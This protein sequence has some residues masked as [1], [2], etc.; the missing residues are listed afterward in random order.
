MATAFIS[1]SPAGRAP[2]V[3]GVPFHVFGPDLVKAWNERIPDEEEMV[4]RQSALLAKAAAGELTTEELNT[5]L[6]EYWLSG[7]IGRA[8]VLGTDMLSAIDLAFGRKGVFYKAGERE[9]CQSA[10]SRP[11]DDHR[12]RATTCVEIDLVVKA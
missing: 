12:C 7:P 11:H 2:A 10:L 3:K 5:E 4:R 6:R 1:G 8:Y 9:I